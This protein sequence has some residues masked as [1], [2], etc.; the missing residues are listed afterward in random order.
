V[1]TGAVEMG[2][3]HATGG[4]STVALTAVRAL[5][6]PKPR[7]ELA[8]GHPSVSG[9]PVRR[10]LPSGPSGQGQRRALPPGP[11]RRPGG[12]VQPIALPPGPSSTPPARRPGVA[13]TRRG[14]QSRTPA[15]R[16]APRPVPPVIQRRTGRRGGR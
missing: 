11:S 14:Y 12:S 15:P 4:A 13:P 2:L 3:G 9:G 5:R 8:A 10:S 6:R 16:S 7:P 1:L